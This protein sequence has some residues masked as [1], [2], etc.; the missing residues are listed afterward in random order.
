MKGSRSFAEHTDSATRLKT[1]RKKPRRFVDLLSY[2]PTKL[3]PGPRD[4]FNRGVRRS[5]SG[6]KIISRRSNTENSTSGGHNVSFG[7]S[8]CPSMKKNGSILTIQPA[9]NVAGSGLCRITLDGEN[10]A[11]R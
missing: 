10:H 4:T 2:V 6:R 8:R 1:S 7:V 5:E 3:H 9:N 11:R